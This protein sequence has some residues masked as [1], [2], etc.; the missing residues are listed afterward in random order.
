MLRTPDSRVLLDKG[1]HPAQENTIPGQSVSRAHNE[2]G[3]RSPIA[4]PVVPLNLEHLQ[5]TRDDADRHRE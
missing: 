1:E 5:L 4:L 2:S 3:A